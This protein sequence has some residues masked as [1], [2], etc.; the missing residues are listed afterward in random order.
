MSEEILVQLSKHNDKSN[1]S[2][3][4]TWSNDLQQSLTINQGDEIMLKQAIIDS[5]I[6]NNL[7]K[8]QEETKISLNFGYYVYLFNQYDETQDP[9][10]TNT[11]IYFGKYSSHV[12]NFNT[13]GKYYLL[14]DWNTTPFVYNENDC[15]IIENKIDITIPVGNYTPKELAQFITAKYQDCNLLH[16]NGYSYFLNSKPNIISTANYAYDI[17]GRTSELP[18][19]IEYQAKFP[20]NRNLNQ[21][22]VYTTGSSESPEDLTTNAVDYSIGCSQMSLE[23][24]ELDQKFQLVLHKPIFNLN[25][26]PP[27][28]SNCFTNLLTKDRKSK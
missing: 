14:Y 10:N 25:E 17:N 20:F 26:T 27:T 22:F 24:D 1:N 19:F 9:V 12:A 3:N 2:K 28:P 7:I 6:S 18:H 15:K 4:N 21:S 13:M 5:R 8:V 16:E 23:Y 11:D